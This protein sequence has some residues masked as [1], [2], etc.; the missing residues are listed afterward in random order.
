[1][2]IVIVSTWAWAGAG[3]ASTPPTTSTPTTS[4]QGSRT[5]WNVG[6]AGLVSASGVPVDPIRRSATRARSGVAGAFARLRSPEPGQQRGLASI[7]VE[8]LAPARRVG[9]RV[10]RV[11]VPAPGV[12]RLRVDRPVATLDALVDHVLDE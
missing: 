10:V 8:P 1:M 4:D 11:A 2:S 9:D 12:T 7:E 6:I 5:G 3:R